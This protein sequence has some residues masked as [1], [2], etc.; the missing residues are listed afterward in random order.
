VTLDDDRWLDRPEATLRWRDGGAGPAILLLHGWALDLDVFEPLVATARRELRLVR[1]D[2]RGYGLSAGEPSLAADVDDAFAVL[3]CA[4]I[5]RCAVLGMSQGARVAAAL[6]RREPRRITHVVLDGA[7]ALRGLADEAHEPELP[8]DR[9]RALAGESS[10][11]L[12]AALRAHPLL[13]LVHADARN[14]ARLDAILARYPARDLHPSHSP[15]PPPVFAAGEAAF[16][17]PALILNGERDSA[18]RQRI[19]RRL[20]QVLPGARRQVL[21]AA[22]HLACVDAPAAYAASL[23]SFLRDSGTT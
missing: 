8:L 19:G 2:R 16:L 11:T 15:S 1:F 12:L 23:C 17:Q 20:A 14:A 3:D 5:E 4:G 10:A 13:T 9:L 18:T 22:G 21:P 7:P 6:A